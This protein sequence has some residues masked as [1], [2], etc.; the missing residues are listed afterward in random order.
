MHFPDHPLFFVGLLL[1][2]L[3]YIAVAVGIGWLFYE[4]QSPKIASQFRTSSAP[5]LHCPMEVKYASR[6]DCNYR[7]GW[8]GWPGFWHFGNAGSRCHTWG[9]RPDCGSHC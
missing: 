5:L 8:I 1:L 9:N 4:I 6:L 3:I 7:G 2:L